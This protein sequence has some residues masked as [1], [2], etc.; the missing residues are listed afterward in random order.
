MSFKEYIFKQNTW[1]TNVDNLKDDQHLF[2]L[3]KEKFIWRNNNF[4]N[5]DFKPGVYIATGMT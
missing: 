1:W 2:A 3:K 5:Y 4:L